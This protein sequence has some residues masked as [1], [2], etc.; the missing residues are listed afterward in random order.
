M[1]WV[2]SEEILSLN[3]MSLYCACIVVVS[4]IGSGF[5]ASAVT[6]VVTSLVFLV[7][8]KKRESRLSLNAAPP[9]INI[10][11]AVTETNMEETVAWRENVAY[12]SASREVKEGKNI[13]TKLKTNNSYRCA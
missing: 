8:R 3:T 5:F 6:L 12:V 4:V 9:P 7:M 2:E 11:D 1:Y 13:S 10:P